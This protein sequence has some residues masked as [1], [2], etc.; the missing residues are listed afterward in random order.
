MRISETPASTPGRQRVG[1]HRRREVRRGRIGVG[2]DDADEHAVRRQAGRL[3][4]PD[5]V[6]GGDPR[7]RRGRAPEQLA[8]GDSRQRR[9]HHRHGVERLRAGARAVAAPGPAPSDRALLAGQPRS[10]AAHQGH[11]HRP[12]AVLDLRPLPRREVAGMRRG[13]DAVDVRASIVPRL[14]HSGARRLRLHARAVRAA[15]GDTEHGHAEGLRRKGL[16]CEPARDG[17][18]G[19][20]HCD[21]S[22]RAGV[23]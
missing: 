17:R 6:A 19:A 10:A 21:D 12:D 18:R 7:G 11:R 16:G 15:D 4:H 2:A 23:V 9:R 5:D 8:G 3:R 22:R 14:R 13:E 20:A 1:P